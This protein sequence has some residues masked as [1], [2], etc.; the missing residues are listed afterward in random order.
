[1]GLLSACNPEGLLNLNKNE[2]N[3][4]NTGNKVGNAQKSADIGAPVALPPRFGTENTPNQ[5]QNATMPN[6][7]PALQPMKGMNIDTLFAEKLKDPD[8][9]FDRVEGAVVDMKKE[10]DV[11][12]PAIV[13]LAAVE[14]DIQNLIRE[15]E[16]VLQETPQQQPIDLSGSS[17]PK[18]DIGQLDPQ[19]KKPPELAKAP[20]KP[21]KTVVKYTPPAEPAKK[22]SAKNFDGV[23]A[24][25]FR[26]GEHSDKVRVA[27]DT[28]KK[29]SYNIDI[30]NDE[31][32]LIIELPDARWEDNQTPSFKNSKMF[33]SMNV[34]PIGNTGTMIIL[35]MKKE[36]QILQKK[37]LSPDKTTEYHRV[38]FDLR[39]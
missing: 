1:M 35:S 6:G 37:I 22:V 31:K 27:F 21:T 28:N 16:V 3:T 13:R 32:L 34:E 5:Q 20:K 14:A 17:G 7:L 9:R 8:D 12:K 25:N 15:L 33:E 18:L 19:P 38:Y 36:A 29:T 4:K 11:Y 10:F 30:D 2:S 23:V 24:L 26:V 39:P